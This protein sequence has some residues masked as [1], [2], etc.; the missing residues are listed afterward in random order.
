MDHYSERGGAWLG[1]TYWSCLAGTWPFGAIR[2]TRES[3]E[4]SIG[5]WPLVRR[6]VI[7]AG[8]VRTLRRRRG[9]LCRGLQVE[10][11]LPSVPRL[12]VYWS[13]DPW[14]LWDALLRL[15]YTTP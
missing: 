7:P 10:S 8:G 9:F 14:R 5:V 13:L 1:Q 2:V 4:V 12:V 11:D 15:G 3:I 6:V